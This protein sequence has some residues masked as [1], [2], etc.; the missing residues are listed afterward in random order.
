MDGLY[1]VCLVVYD[2]VCNVSDTT[3]SIINLLTGIENTSNS[4][5]T[6]SPNPTIDH[7]TLSFVHP[8]L[9][10]LDIEIKNSFNQ[11][12]SIIENLYNQSKIS[13][14]NMPSGIYFM[15]LYSN[16]QFISTLKLIKL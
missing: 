3:C 11:T 13:L 10:N 12:V 1:N 8:T 16:H 14:T 4:Q 2:S 9:K 5:I 6:I 15:S 7:V